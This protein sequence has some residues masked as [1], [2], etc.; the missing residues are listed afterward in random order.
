MKFIISG[1]NV[2]ITDAIRKQIE[3]KLSKLDKFFGAET[4]A[5]VTV[6]IVKNNQYVEATI[7][8]NNM[9]FRAEEGA[10]DLYQ[11]IDKIADVMERQI[12]RNKTRLA[13]RL[14][15]G[16]FIKE[17]GAAEVREEVDFDIVR[18]KRFKV[19]PM[20]AEE[21]ILQMNLLGH[22][23]YLFLNDETKT[24]NIVYKRKAGGYGL[25]IPE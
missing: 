18:T 10:P 15:E 25:L 5:H 22:E 11:S 14:H 17:A 20:T 3:K 16:A 9:F 13:K 2:E 23:F 24:M 7:K 4:T 8:H 19:M 1:R 21:A 12:R 6:S